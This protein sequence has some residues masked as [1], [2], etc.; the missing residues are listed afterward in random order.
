MGEDL[1]L[2]AIYL[3]VALGALIAAAV[4][5]IRGGIGPTG[6]DGVFL[7]GVCLFFAAVFGLMGAQTIRHTLLPDWLEQRR[8][9]K[10][11]VPAAPPAATPQSK[12]AR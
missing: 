12:A 9:G 5:L 8:S 11:G 4:V 3:L 6:V 10:A 7:M 1:A 2:A